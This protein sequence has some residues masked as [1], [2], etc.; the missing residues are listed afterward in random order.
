MDDIAK[1]LGVSKKTIY[2]HYPDKDE[3]VI[4]V[5]KHNIDRHIEHMDMCCGPAAKDAIDELLMVNR[6]VGNMIL[7]Y[8]PIMFYDLQ[9][10]H[11][12][13]WLK[14]KEFR[15]KEILEKIRQNLERGIR[16]GY[17][18]TDLDI[19]IL[20]IMRLEQVDMCFNY[21]IYPVTEFRFD[22]VLMHLTEHFVYG[23]ATI[24]GHQLINKYKS[25]IE[26]NNQ[27]IHQ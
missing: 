24:K 15:N 3:L 8:N 16:E 23:L 21:D 10:Y 26:E 9:K 18:R 4:A 20:S 6:E 13:A 2:Q 17:Y 12:K 5:T 25:I 14:F 1:Q 22:K 27:T 19:R 11:P 7:M